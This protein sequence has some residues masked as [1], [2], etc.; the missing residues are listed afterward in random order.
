MLGRIM[1]VEFDCEK[2]NL[3]EFRKYTILVYVFFYVNTV[4]RDKYCVVFGYL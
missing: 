3:Y 1:A 2:Q 4:R